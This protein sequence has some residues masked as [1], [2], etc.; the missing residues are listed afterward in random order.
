M[1]LLGDTCVVSD[2]DVRQNEA[3]PAETARAARTRPWAIVSVAAISWAA[4]TM[5]ILHL[6]SSQSPVRDP[7]SS[8]AIT[9]RGG[10]MLE[11]S[12]LSL[13]IGS[14]AVIGALIVSGTPL[15]TTAQLLLAMWAL[16]L[17][18]GAIFPASYGQ[19]GPVDGEIH[20][21]A[22]LVAFLSLPGAGYSLLDR[23]RSVPGLERMRAMLSRM[24]AISLYCLVLFGVS[25]LLAAFP[26]VPFAEELSSVL[27][28]GLTQRFALIADIAL[29]LTVVVVAVKMASQRRQTPENAY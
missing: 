10:G 24:L 11:A 19:V 26:A 22:S 18:V 4:F 27:P 25:Y 21:Y 17:V 8:Y 28:V 15:S 29:L 14:F 13:A 23:V 9:D 3:V 20:R 1:T 5:T 16:G 2:L 7:L 12:V 6:I